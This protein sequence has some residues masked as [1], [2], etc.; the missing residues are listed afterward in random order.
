MSDGGWPP[1]TRRH[2]SREVIGKKEVSGQDL[3]KSMVQAEDTE[4][5]GSGAE[6]GFLQ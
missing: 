1:K 2:I 4:S 6:I 5:T 3:G